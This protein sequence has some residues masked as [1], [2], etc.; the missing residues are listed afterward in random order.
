MALSGRLVFWRYACIA[1]LFFGTYCARRF[2]QRSGCAFRNKPPARLSSRQRHRSPAVFRRDGSGG[3]L[4]TPLAARRRHGAVEAA[5]PASVTAEPG[6]VGIVVGRGAVR[7]RHGRAGQG[8]A[9]RGAVP[10]GCGAGLVDGMGAGLAGGGQC[11]HCLA[12]GAGAMAD[13]VRA[14]VLVAR[15]LGAGAVGLGAGGVAAVRVGGVVVAG[16]VVAMD[17]LSGRWAV[18]PVWPG[19]GLHQSWCVVGQCVAPDPAEA[20]DRVGLG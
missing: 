5:Q 11:R 14:V 3:R 17:G 16:T 9:T 19:A 13:A 4:D 7:P 10:G 20:L 8:G 18:Q 6:P 12:H 2:P 15:K 1:S